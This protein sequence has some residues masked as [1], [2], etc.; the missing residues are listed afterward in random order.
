MS[1]IEIL[2]RWRVQRLKKERK[3]LDEIDIRTYRLRRRLKLKLRLRLRKRK[4]RDT[5][6]GLITSSLGLG[7]GGRC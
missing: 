4:K 2:I 3:R 6:E 5:G 7:E 1:S